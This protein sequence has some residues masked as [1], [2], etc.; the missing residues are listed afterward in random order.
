MI[1][2][3]H[4]RSWWVISMTLCTNDD[5]ISGDLFARNFY[6]IGLKMKWWKF[7]G[8]SIGITQLAIKMLFIAYLTVFTDLLAWFPVEK[9][10][11]KF[12]LMTSYFDRDVIKMTNFDRKWTQTT[13]AV[14]LIPIKAILKQDFGLSFLAPYDY[15]LI[16]GSH[17]FSQ[18]DFFRDWY[19]AYCA[20]KEP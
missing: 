8:K 14:I 4:L 15:Q 10:R 7:F 5:V 11:I 9:V 12:P 1:F 17:T 20:S 13:C 6:K 18:A 16:L 3:V 2:Q 19:L